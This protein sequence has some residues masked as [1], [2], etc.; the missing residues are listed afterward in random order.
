LAHDG[1]QLSTQFS[2]QRGYLNKRFQN[3]LGPKEREEF[4]RQMGDLAEY[5]VEVLNFEPNHNLAIKGLEDIEANLKAEAGLCILFLRDSG[6]K[7]AT[8]I[9]SRFYSRVCREGTKEAATE[10]AEAAKTVAAFYS[11]WRAAK[12]NTGLDDVYRKLMKVGDGQ[13]QIAPMS[14]SMSGGY[15]TVGQLRKYLLTALGDYAVCDY[16]LPHAIQNLKFDLA[17]PVCKFALI[18]STHDTIKDPETPGLVKIGNKGVSPCLDPRYWVSAD[19]KT[20]EHIAPV[21]GKLEWPSDLY[22]STERFQS[23]GNLVLLPGDLNSALGNNNWQIKHLYYRYLAE[24]DVAVVTALETEASEQGLILQRHTI[25]LL[26]NASYKRQIEPLVTVG[27][28]GI[29]NQDIVDRR[30]KRIATILWTRMTDW[31]SP[32]KQ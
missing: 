8:T 20:L 31:L 1:H 3:C 25:D 15:P 18:V 14:A 7:M 29:W 30:A 13:K 32:G 5:W 22:E 27:S 24:T 2:V 12:P 4:V 23:V 19:L 28:N 11:L 6:H 17:R 10:F 26:T 16:W 21:K 9:L